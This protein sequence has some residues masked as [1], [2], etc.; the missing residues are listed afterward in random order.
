MKALVIGSGVVG[1][2]I[3]LALQDSYSEVILLER[4]Q[5]TIAASYGN[6]GHIAIEQVDPL[7]SWDTI[8]SASKRLFM[9]GGALSLP[10]R[11]VTAWLPFSLRMMWAASP[12]RFAAGKTALKGLI[13]AAMPAWE[14]RLE[15]IG[16]RDLLKRDGHFVVWETVET[17]RLGLNAWQKADT[18]TARFRPATV[19]EL[20]QL[21]A[22]TQKPVKGAI[23]FENTGQISDTL[24]LLETLAEAF[25]QR[26]GRILYETVERLIRKDQGLWAVLSDGERVTADAIVVSAGIASKPLL[27]SIGQPVP[28]IAERG[29]HIQAKAPEWPQD[30]PP[31]VFE[32]RSMIVTRF[33]SGLRA[34]SF[35][36]FARATDPADPRKW[37][38]LKAHAADLGLPFSGDVAEW[39]GARPTLPDYLPA[40]GHL[41][42][43]LF[44]A[45]G[46]QH[47]GLTLAA[48]TGDVVAKMISDG[49]AP[50]AFDIKRFS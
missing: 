48:V 23:R 37:A 11:A 41:E 15:A 8:K 9:R 12:R 30:L 25:R 33:E 49:Q 20:G 24:R 7:A 19:E 43:N 22:V 34:A 5:Q 26:G 4:Q 40:I 46:H 10:P 31:V 36:E 27:E 47:L 44:Y 2:N 6:A 18:G 45:F 16:A 35:V 32:D 14:Q 38:R 50:K 42:S 13:I 17:A 39:T 29:Y 1:L 3:A 28:M 21:A